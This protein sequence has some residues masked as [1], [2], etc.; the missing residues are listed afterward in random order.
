MIKS[1]W[2]RKYNR[3]KACEIYVARRAPEIEKELTGRIHSS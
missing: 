3:G 2:N 1:T